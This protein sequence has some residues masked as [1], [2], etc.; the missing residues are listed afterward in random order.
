M[1]PSAPVTVAIPDIGVNATVVPVGV[2]HDGTIATP[3]DPH[4]AGWYR[5]SRTPGQQGPAV[6][7]GHVDAPRIG[8]AVFYR[9][10]AVKPGD[11]IK[12]TRQDHTTAS[13]TVDAVR[14]YRKT[15]FPTTQLYAG[16][17]QATLSLITCSDWDPGIHS[18][19]GNA[20]VFA[21]L[22]ETGVKGSTP[23]KPST[24]RVTASG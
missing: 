22:S 21:H 5:F 18:Y 12:I 17:A 11:V 4:D 24:A 6:I 1:S 13:F 23:G 14:E 16:T 10:G 20:I 15:S 9:L 8:P 19:R 3:P 2:N 7:V